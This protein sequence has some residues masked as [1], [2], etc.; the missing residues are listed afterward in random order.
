ML[1]SWDRDRRSLLKRKIILPLDDDLEDV[2][3]K[4]RFLKKDHHISRYWS[5]FSTEHALDLSSR[6]T[7]ALGVNKGEYSVCQYGVMVNSCGWAFK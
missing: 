5:N 1:N 6:E 4:R 7:V 3:Y 2:V